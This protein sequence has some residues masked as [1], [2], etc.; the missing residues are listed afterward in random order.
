MKLTE[1]EL[2]ELKLLAHDLQKV[3]LENEAGLRSITNVVGIRSTQ[4]LALLA[5][6]IIDKR[7]VAFSENFEQ[8]N[9]NLNNK[10]TVELT[11][12]GQRVVGNAKM[13]DLRGL[14]ITGN[15]VTGE[16]WRVFA[17]FGK[18]LN[19]IGSDTPFDMNIVVKP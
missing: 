18:Y 19:G 3:W 14:E 7:P 4:V 16:G 15:K 9:F 6:Q 2:E 13:D 10:V 17:F 12:V 8:M 1:R 5:K 11:E